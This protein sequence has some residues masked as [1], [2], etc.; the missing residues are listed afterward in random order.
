MTPREVRLRGE[1][2]YRQRE[3][4]ASMV[5]WQIQH[6]YGSALMPKHILR[7]RPQPPQK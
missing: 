3:R 5:I 1:A 2:Y 6:R 7:G 4:E